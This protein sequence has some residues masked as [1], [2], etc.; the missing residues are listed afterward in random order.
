MNPTRKK[1][2]S[3]RRGGFDNGSDRRASPLEAEAGG[4]DPLVGGKRKQKEPDRTLPPDKSLSFSTHN[5]P[6]NTTVKSVIL[7]K[8]SKIIT[9]APPQMG[10]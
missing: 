9:I 4:D 8:T 3:R 10:G 7:V 1:L 5:L 2:I 6:C